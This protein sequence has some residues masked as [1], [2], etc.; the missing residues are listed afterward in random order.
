MVTPCQPPRV[1]PR[2]TQ[3][4]QSTRLLKRWTTVTEYQLYWLCRAVCKK[5]FN[6][7]NL[8]GCW[9]SKHLWHAIRFDRRPVTRLLKPQTATTQYH[10]SSESRTVH[11]ALFKIITPNGYLSPKKATTHYHVSSESRTVHKILFKLIALNGYLSSKS[12]HTVS[13]F[14]QWVKNCSQGLIQ[15]YNSKRLLKLQI[16]VT[17]YRIFSV[18][19]TVHTRSLFRVITLNCCLTSTQT[20]TWRAPRAFHKTWS[21]ATTPDGC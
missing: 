7:T 19:R 12:H 17:Q 20:Q 8:K 14:P 3:A 21:M 13:I 15:G 5:L 4:N 1:N 16:A 2:S 18:S 11:K 9:K 10:I 6:V